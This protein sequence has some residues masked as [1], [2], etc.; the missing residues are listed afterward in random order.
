MDDIVGGYFPDPPPRYRRIP[1]PLH[2]GHNRNFAY[3]D[4]FYKCYV[5]GA[6]GDIF[7]LVMEYFKI[8]FCASVT[9]LNHDF[10]LGLELDNPTAESTSAAREAAERL[11]EAREARKRE[12]DV[13]LE[14]YHAALDRWVRLDRQLWASPP[15]TAE[16]DEAE[17]HIAEAAYLLEE[18]EMRLARIRGADGPGH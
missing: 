3:T 1:C 8:D 16:H 7:K 11:R 4:K 9:K 17:R 18:E 2:G 6:A 10:H 15:G 14:A 5:C 12:E 13:A